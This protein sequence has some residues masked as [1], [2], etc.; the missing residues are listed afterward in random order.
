MRALAQAGGAG[1]VVALAPPRGPCR[2]G[3]GTGGMR[4][5]ITGGTGGLGML[6]AGWLVGTGVASELL[7]L[8]RSGRATS[9]PVPGGNPAWSTL[10]RS[11]ACVRVVAADVA[12]AEDAACTWREEECNGAALGAVVHAAGVLTDAMLPK[13]DLGMLRRYEACSEFWTMYRQPYKLQV[14]KCPLFL[15]SCSYMYPTCLVVVCQKT[16]FCAKMK[17]GNVQAA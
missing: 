10:A 6:V 2:V 3:R 13:Q 4:V 15:P 1:K 8:G 17:S 16:A 14:L 11:G 5:A 12:C 7:L 9:T